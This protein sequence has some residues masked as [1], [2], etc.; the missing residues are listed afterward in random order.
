MKL[1]DYFSCSLL[2]DPYPLPQYRNRP[3]D[4]Y[5]STTCLSSRNH[6]ATSTIK[7]TT[8]TPPHIVAHEHS[9]PRISTRYVVQQQQQQQQHQQKQQQN[10][11]HRINGCPKIRQAKS[12]SFIA[13]QADEDEVL[14]QSS[15]LKSRLLKAHKNLDSCDEEG[16]VRLQEN[17]A[18]QRSRTLS[19]GS[20]D[21]FDLQ[22][23][24]SYHKKTRSRDLRSANHTKARPNIRRPK[25][26]YQAGNPSGLIN[27]C[28]LDEK[29]TEVVQPSQEDSYLFLK[30][31]VAAF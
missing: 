31:C 4:D 14:Y 23:V 27:D 20:D 29:P 5:N 15:T 9:Q 24:E 1:L 10:T 30:V 13:K 26:S 17:S 3:E 21:D 19:S 28:D 11:K 22:W 16:S 18:F 25:S 2:A 7:T 6:S 12:S 8:M